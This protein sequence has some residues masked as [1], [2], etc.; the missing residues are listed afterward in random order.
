[1]TPEQHQEAVIA[2]SAMI[3]SWLQRREQRMR[4]DRNELAA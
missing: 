4:R 3:S 2:L 1:M